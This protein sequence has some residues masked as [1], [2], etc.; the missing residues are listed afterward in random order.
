MET[1][2]KIRQIIDHIKPF[3]QADGGD[4]EFLKYEDG[5]V[6]ISLTGA[7]I[8]CSMIDTTLNDGIKSWIID[9]VPEV[10]DVVLYQM[11][12]DFDGYPFY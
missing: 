3:I 12:E 11:A 1:E 5:V 2:D 7:C 6:T 10:Q 8:G 4:L 9:E